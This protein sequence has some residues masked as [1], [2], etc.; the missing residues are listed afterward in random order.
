MSSQ[1]KFCSGCASVLENRDVDGRQRPVCPKCGRVVYHDPKIA[2][3]C[4]IERQ[5]K[6][7][8]IRRNNQ[9]GYGLWSMPGGY[10]DR[11]EVVEEAAAREV[12]EETGLKVEVQRLVGLFSETGHPVVVVA[13]AAR[14]TGGRLSA[15]PEAQDIGFFPLDDLPEMA[16]PRDKL[17]LEKWRAMRQF[18]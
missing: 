12:E 8:M 15:G 5:G 18:D 11:G 7:L 1:E 4:I 13:F 6:V 14:E 17:I 9:V 16:F 3:T 2:A 10:V